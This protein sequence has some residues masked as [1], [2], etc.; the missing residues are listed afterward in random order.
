[1]SVQGISRIALLVSSGGFKKKGPG[2]KHSEG[3]IFS[4]KLGGS[5][6]KG[7]KCTEKIRKKI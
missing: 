7:G 5:L 2:G 3:R 6:L 1:M 4:G